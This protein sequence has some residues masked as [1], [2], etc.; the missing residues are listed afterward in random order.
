MWRRRPLVPGHRVAQAV[1]WTFC[2]SQKAPPLRGA[3]LVQLRLR[4]CQPRPQVALQTDHSVHVDHPPFTGRT[5]KDWVRERGL[6]QTCQGPGRE[7]PGAAA[8]QEGSPGGEATLCPGP[9][10]LGST[11]ST[12][13]LPEGVWGNRP[14]CSS[15]DPRL[16]P[17]LFTPMTPAPPPLSAPGDTQGPVAFPRLLLSPHLPLPTSKPR[18]HLTTDDPQ[19]MSHF[20]DT[21]LSS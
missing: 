15:W 18:D 17:Q 10:E 1:F 6:P 13:R 2:P 19:P 14:N 20:P 5:E 21:P 8:V 3:G 4:F 16:R 7:R 11:R 9:P 12:A